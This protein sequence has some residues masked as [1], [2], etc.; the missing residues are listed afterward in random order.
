[1][2]LII[3]NN[4]DY[5]TNKIIKF[6]SINGYN[7]LR[8]TETQ[9]ISSI[10]L[11]LNSDNVSL[12]FSVN[13]KKIDYKSIKSFW[14]RKNGIELFKQLTVKAP[15]LN[16]HNLT[17]IEDFLKEYEIESI[18]DFIILMLERKH[19]LGNIKSGD[20][21]KLIS[22]L[23]AKESGLDIPN[24]FIGTNLEELKSFE[25]DRQCILKPIED[26]YAYDGGDYWLYT[27]NKLSTKKVF[28]D[29]ESLIYPSILQEYIEKK[30]ELRVFYLN[31]KCYSMAIFSQ[32]DEQTKIDFR[33]Y[34]EEKPNRMVPFQ[35]PNNIE[36]KINDFMDRMN[37]NTGSID[38]I[39]TPN[40]KYVFLEVNP[41][42]QYAMVGD[43]CN[44]PLDSLIFN[45]LTK[46]ER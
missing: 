22:F 13:N 20:G 24:S 29:K 3:S 2:I 30:V 38:L 12:K 43:N 17:H 39:L 27:K 11:E 36:I 15:F 7:V 26:G 21:N 44:Y 10:S 19:Y 9:F 33:N 46:Y 40:D 5:S 6:L 34:N 4:F 37:L 45:Y 42:G 25:N 1:M 28:T 16:Q 18:R 41:V 8:L 23:Y 32:N 31:K 35:L 14:F